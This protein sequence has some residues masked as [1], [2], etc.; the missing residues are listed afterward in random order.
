MQ[1]QFSTLVDISINNNGNLYGRQVFVFLLNHSV[2]L[3]TA[4]NLGAS[5]QQMRRVFLI[6]PARKDRCGNNRRK[7]ASKSKWLNWILQFDVK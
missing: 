7:I 4:Q 3:Q 1:E 2:Q 6:L 5:S